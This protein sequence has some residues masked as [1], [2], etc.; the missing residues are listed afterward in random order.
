MDVIFG[1]IIFVLALVGF[2]VFVN[3][4]KGI[5][6]MLF[7]KKTEDKVMETVNKVNEAIKQEEVK[8]EP[9]KPVE[10]WIWVEGYKAT[11]KDMTC[12]GYQYELGMQHDMPDDADIKECEQG[13][14]LCKTLDDVFRYYEV[15]DGHRFFK[16]RALVRKSHYERYGKTTEEYEEYV[17]LGRTAYGFTPHFWGSN[18]YDKMVARSIIFEQELTVDEIIESRYDY[19]KTWPDKYKNLV[20]QTGIE[21]ANEVLKVDKLVEIGF[22]ETFARYITRQDM[23]ERALSVGSQPDLSMD[24]KCW[25]IFK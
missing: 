11:E 20:L 8:S 14:H 22:S 6:Q 5:F 7:K 4:M 24:M 25:L 2:V 3:S 13:F 12:R 10:E 23:Y 16:V 18:V 17:K 15:C 9:V 21:N 1:G 19:V